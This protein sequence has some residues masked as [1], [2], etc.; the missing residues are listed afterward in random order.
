MDLL[1]KDEQNVLMTISK[2]SNVAEGPES[3]RDVLM[4]IYRIKDIKNKTLSQLTQIPV[5]T[6]AAIRGELIKEGILENKTMF[7]TNG[8]TFVEEKL[9][10]RFSPCP[11]NENFLNEFSLESFPS[12]IL[13]REIIDFLKKF[14]SN[15]P[16]S[17]V[18]LDQS[19]ATFE[20]QM[21]RLALLLLN[22]D[23]E[24]RSILLL[25][26]DDATSAIISSTG[27]AKRIVVIDVDERI[28]SFVSSLPERYQKTKIETYHI[29]LRNPLLKNLE[30]N[31]DI[32]FTDPPY[33][34]QGA[35]LFFQRGMYALRNQGTKFYLSYGPKQPFNIWNLQIQIE[36]S[37]FYLYKIFQSFNK[38]KGNLR[39]GQFS[40]LFIFK[41]VHSPEI[42]SYHNVFPYNRELYT[43][44]VKQADKPEIESF[45]Q[46]SRS[47]GYH[48]IAELYGIKSIGI[49]DPNSLYKKTLELCE[50]VKL[51]V[52]DSYLYI[53]P[54]QGLSI[55]IELAESHIGLH[56]WP[57]HDYMSLDVF[58]CDEPQKA[59]NFVNEIKK[60]IKPT[61][62]EEI[63]INRGL[64]AN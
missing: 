38:Y 39:L 22:G 12:S 52:V 35:K 50:K 9:G 43:S 29:D 47:I 54:P 41:L 58:I 28:L 45:E 31:F 30:K 25:G 15:R 1:E 2:N 42:L 34:L 10:F 21:K 14:L 60:L 57:E 6:L 46:A 62:V 53:Y 64:N 13:T 59:H 37:G 7:T 44:E 3:V 26:D 11:I 36:N 27:L 61:K 17:D 48:I 8:K 18:Q 5:P 40:N 33:T 55:I 19:M 32:V 16:E 56:T 24:G 63:V 49:L 51:R 23:V 20:T 4:H